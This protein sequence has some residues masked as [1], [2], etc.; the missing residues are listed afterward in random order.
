MFKLWVMVSALAVAAMLIAFAVVQV[1]PVAAANDAA[2]GVTN[3]EGTGMQSHNCGVDVRDVHVSAVTRA[4]TKG[5]QWRRYNDFL[6]HNCD[7]YSWSAMVD[8]GNPPQGQVDRPQV[9]R[10]Q[11]K[12]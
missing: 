2:P 12:R 9:E 5:E 11:N 10:R 8:V 4:R 1:Q 6:R 7:T 3:T